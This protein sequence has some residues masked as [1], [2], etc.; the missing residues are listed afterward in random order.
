MLAVTSDKALLRAVWELVEDPEQPTTVG[1]V[2]VAQHLERLGNGPISLDQL[3]VDARLLRQL[4]L[5]KLHGAN[6]DRAV[7]LTQV[8]ALLATNLAF[9]KGSGATAPRTK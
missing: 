7:E 9:A 8:G 4:G 1:L 6:G 2:A 5:M 3:D